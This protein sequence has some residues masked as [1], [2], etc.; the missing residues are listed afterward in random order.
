M[1][2]RFFWFVVGEF[3]CGRRVDK[4]NALLV[5]KYYYSMPESKGRMSKWGVWVVDKS[6]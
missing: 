3:Q 5:K 2:K 6:N 4:L 1:V